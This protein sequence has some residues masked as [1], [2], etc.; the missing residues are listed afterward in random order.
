MRS[1]GH[2][3]A[4]FTVHATKKLLDRVKQPVRP[5]VAD[6]APALGNWYANAIFWKPQQ[7]AL[8]MNERTLLPVFVP[9][10]PAS[11]L[12]RRFPEQLAHVLLALGVPRDL[13]E[14][15]IALMDGGS[16]SKTG[17]PGAPTRARAQLR[18]P[19][20][21][22]DRCLRQLDAA[23]VALQPAGVAAPS[24][25]IGQGRRGHGKALRHG[26]AVEAAVPH[27][28]DERGG[29]DLQRAG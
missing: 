4:I 22:F 12:M 3:P 24:G 19:V 25:S 5:P 23:G 9:L 28:D 6:P 14:E 11:S 1:G 7:V 13:V 15:E 8:L 21:D 26:A 16:Y 17:R 20:L 29:I 18:Y 27:G 2:T 10:A